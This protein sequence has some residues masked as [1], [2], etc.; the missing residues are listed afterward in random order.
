MRRRS[1]GRPLA[2]RVYGALARWLLDGHFGADATDVFEDLYREAIRERG[3]VGGGFRLA[4]TLSNPATLGRLTAPLAAGPG[5]VLAAEHCAISLS[6]SSWM[7]SC[8]MPE[9]AA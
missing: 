4:S 7:Y 8:D 6:N 5:E 9:A 3:R 2:V 1:G